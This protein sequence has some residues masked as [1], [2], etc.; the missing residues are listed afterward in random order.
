MSQR[1]RKLDDADAFL[2]PDVVDDDAPG[3]AAGIL[4]LEHLDET[5]L[6]DDDRERVPDREREQEDAD[7]EPRIG[8]IPPARQYEERAEDAKLD[9]DDQAREGA[10]LVHH[11]CVP[12]A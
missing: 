1:I 12:S 8:P 3:P 6:V 5:E 4:I 11:G 7:L 10:D 9:E 2:L